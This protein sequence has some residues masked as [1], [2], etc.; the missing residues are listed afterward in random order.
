LD[1]RTGVPDRSVRITR[2]TA[3]PARTVIGAKRAKPEARHPA[4][5]SPQGREQ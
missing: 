1:G 3:A 5:T 2:T 4:K